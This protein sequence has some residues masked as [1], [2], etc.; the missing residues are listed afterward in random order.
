MI[1][2]VSMFIGTSGKANWGKPPATLAISP[3]RN[4]FRSPTITINVTD[5]IATR[6]AGMAFVIFG[7]TQIITIVTA[8]SASV[9]YSIGPAI[10]LDVPSALTIWNCCSCASPITIASPLTKPSITGCGTMR[11]NLPSRKMP[12][13]SCKMPISTTVANRYSAP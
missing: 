11:M 6:G 2:S 1:L 4:T 3:T 5:T 7:V 12:A 9:I 8:T 13:S 10:Q